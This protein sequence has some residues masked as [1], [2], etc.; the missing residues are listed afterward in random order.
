MEREVTV[1]S[2]SLAQAEGLAIR[3][4]ELIAVIAGALGFTILLW[5]HERVDG[6]WPAALVFGAVAVAPLLLRAL[7]AQ[8]PENRLL[9]FVADFGPIV[10]I[11]GLYLHLNPVLD[12]VNL[13][14]ADDWLV[15]LDQQVFGLQ[16]SI[17]LDRNLPLWAFDLFL[18]AYT[19]YFV[20]PALLGLVLWFKRKEVQFDEWVTALMFFYAVNYA[21]YALVPAMGPRYFQAAYFDGPVPGMWF[22]NQLDLM[23]RD[24]PLARDCFPSGHTGISLLVLGYAWKEER[25]FFWAVLPVIVCLII[26]TLAGRFH[27][28]IDLIAA[29]P[30]TV[31]SLAVAAA[32]KRRLPEGVV[33][34]RAST[35]RRAR[36]LVRGEG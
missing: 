34:A 24:S 20:W 23:F 36:A 35:W 22:A 19:T 18:G 2:T 21:F 29:L 4:G 14:I 15:R 8:L 32:L 11:V 3:S 25:K 6:W 17:W 12:A 16:P 1:P 10:Y 5:N 27:Y 9:R 30:L 28:G 26:G 31:T 33:V 13:P 7:Q